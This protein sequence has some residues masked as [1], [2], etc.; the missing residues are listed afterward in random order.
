M[1]LASSFIPSSFTPMS[2]TLSNSD[3]SFI[4]FTRCLYKAK[5]VVQ[6]LQEFSKTV[7][8]TLCL[9]PFAQKQSYDPRI[10]T[11]EFIKHVHQYL[12]D[13]FRKFNNMCRVLLI[14]LSK[15]ESNQPVRR[16]RIVSFRQ[17]VLNE[18]KKADKVR[19]DLL[20]SVQD[21][22]QVSKLPSPQSIPSSSDYDEENDEDDDEEPDSETS[23]EPT[24]SEDSTTSA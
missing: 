24:S 18:W 14:V 15:L 3:R 16:E 13:S 23:L 17:E 10:S 8:P 19:Q 2:S 1:N 9:S 20:L 7:G 21:S 12:E 4:E 11:D 22:Y 5:S 6:E